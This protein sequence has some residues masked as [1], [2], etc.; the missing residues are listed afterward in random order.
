M[1]NLDTGPTEVSKHHGYEWVSVRRIRKLEQIER[2]AV[3][4]DRIA[5]IDPTADEYNEWLTNWHKALDELHMILDKG[6]NILQQF[7]Q[8]FRRG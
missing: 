8:I 4:I 7:N 2:A 6:S 3:E 1:S 5:Q